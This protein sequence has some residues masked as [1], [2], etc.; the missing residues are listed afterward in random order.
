MSIGNLLTKALIDRFL[1]LGTLDILIT[2]ACVLVCAAVVAVV[3][4]YV[5]REP[6]YISATPSQPFWRKRTTQRV[7]ACCVVAIV[8]FAIV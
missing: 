5:R 3:L 4:F 2:V 1:A 6:V 7:C 8:V